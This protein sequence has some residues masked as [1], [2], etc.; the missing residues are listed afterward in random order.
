MAWSRSAS[1]S[2]MVGDLP[3]SST[4]TFFMLPAA[5]CTISRPT[6]VDPVKVILSTPGVRGQCRSRGGSHA[7]HDIE[8][9]LR[10]ARLERSARRDAAP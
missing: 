6:S 5:A 1:A 3:P 4:V 2:T 10:E 7:G 8:H 9:A